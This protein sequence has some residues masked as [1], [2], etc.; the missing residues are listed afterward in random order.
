MYQE[1][2]R[3]FAHKIQI[4]GNLQRDLSRMREEK[5]NLETAL[6]DAE[7]FQVEMRT[8]K[9]LDDERKDRQIAKLQKELK[10]LQRSKDEMKISYTDSTERFAQ[11]SSSRAREQEVCSNNL[12]SHSLRICFLLYYFHKP[13]KNQIVS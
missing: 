9:L 6:V 1:K 4:I 12:K 11:E 2:P 8:E 7:N 5:E 13:T 10:E 3:N